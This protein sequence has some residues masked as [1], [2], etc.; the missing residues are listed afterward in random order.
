MRILEQATAQGKIQWE[1]VG[2][3]H[4]SNVEAN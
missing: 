1:A 4:V 3:V 2:K